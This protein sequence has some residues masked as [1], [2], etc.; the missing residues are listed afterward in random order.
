MS[1]TPAVAYADAVF[2]CAVGLAAHYTRPIV[3]SARRYD[4]R[5]QCGA[6]AFVVLNEDG[7]ILTAAHLLEPATLHAGH[8]AEIAR[9]DAAAREIAAGEGTASGKAKRVRSLGVNPGWI[10]NYSI[11]TGWEG[12]SVAEFHVLPGADLALGRIE[13]FDPALVSSYPVLRD[14]ATLVPGTTVCKLGYPFHSVSTTFDEAAGTFV[15]AEGALPM[16]LFALEGMITRLRSGSRT[17]GGSPPVTYVETSTPGLRGQSGG[18]I[19]DAEG[20]LC[21]I[22]VHTVHYPLGFSPPFTEQGGRRVEEHQFLNV[23]VGV[24]AETILR[25]LARYGVRV[26][27]S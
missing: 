6:G 5:V 21:A 27:G 18:P 23:G 20:R 8:Q 19:F 9:H 11:W 17:P 14:P 22:Q 13:P 16:P 7:W 1:S 3:V 2:A 12:R 25:F 10:R 15:F 4:G 24:S 26:A